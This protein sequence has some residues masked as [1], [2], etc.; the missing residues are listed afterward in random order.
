MLW[1]LRP[2]LGMILLAISM[3]ASSAF[4]I[5]YHFLLST[6]DNIFLVQQVGCGHWFTITAVCDHRNDL[7]CLLCVDPEMGEYR[8]SQWMKPRESEQ[9]ISEQQREAL[10]LD[11]ASGGSRIECLD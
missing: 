6:Q 2:R 9:D 3:A 8:V 7:L 1:T 11:H 10:F 4:G 5:C